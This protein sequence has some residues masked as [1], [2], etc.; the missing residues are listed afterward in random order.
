MHDVHRVFKVGSRLLAMA[1]SNFAVF[2][3]VALVT[4]FRS[5]A[6]AH[7]DVEP[8][9]MRLSTVGLGG[10]VGDAWCA[11]QVQPATSPVLSP[12]FLWTAAR[13]WPSYTPLGGYTRIRYQSTTK[14]GCNRSW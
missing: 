12:N 4:S 11:R 9:A 10:C 1:M 7:A 3:T 8:I 5:V 6:A 14:S 13:L 2:A